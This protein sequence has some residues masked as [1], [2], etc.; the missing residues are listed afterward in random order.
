MVRKAQLPYHL[1]N[2]LSRDP[3]NSRMK[4]ENSA[5]AGTPRDAE[6]ILM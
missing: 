4:Q 6:I 1:G 5:A 2:Q 3:N